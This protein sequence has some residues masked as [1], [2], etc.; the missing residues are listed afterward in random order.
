MCLC[1]E[2]EV[3][4]TSFRKSIVQYVCEITCENIAMPSFFEKN[5]AVLEDGLLYR[6]TQIISRIVLNLQSMDHA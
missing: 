1:K 6:G 2:Q 3:G 4:K 5:N